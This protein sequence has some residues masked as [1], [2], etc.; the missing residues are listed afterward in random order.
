MVATSLNIVELNNYSFESRNW[1]SNAN[2]VILWKILKYSTKNFTLW[3][4]SNE[5][6]RYRDQ[7]MTI[8]YS[9]T[10]VESKHKKKV[11]V[12]INISV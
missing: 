4:T 7:C 11:G 1:Y 3:G 2:I 6:K 9:K 5:Q 8:F 12:R 10:Q